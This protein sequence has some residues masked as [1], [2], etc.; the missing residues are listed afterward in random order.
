MND[1][2]IRPSRDLRNNYAELSRL[3]NDGDSAIAV[4][5]NGK[6]DTLLMS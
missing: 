5:V 6:Q 3:C 1:V 4:T 2:L